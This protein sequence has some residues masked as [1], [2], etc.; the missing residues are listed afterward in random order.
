MASRA[1]LVVA[2]L[3]ELAAFGA[4]PLVV[5]SP[6]AELVVVVA[7]PLVSVVVGVKLTGVKVLLDDPPVALT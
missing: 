2:A 7:S 4:V 6:V 5:E 3:E 1:V